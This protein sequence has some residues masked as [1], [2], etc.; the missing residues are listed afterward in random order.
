VAVHVE[1]ARQ[2]WEEGHR[3]LQ[4][5][6]SDPARYRLLISQVEVLTEELR[7]RLG[8]VFA[9]RD[10]AEEYERAE[11]WARDATAEMSPPGRPGDLATAE[12]AAFH[13]YARAARDYAP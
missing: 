10:L 1:N 11:T 4:E 7:R 2:Q 5:A 12:D 8:Q 9:L 13:L 3:R 6:A